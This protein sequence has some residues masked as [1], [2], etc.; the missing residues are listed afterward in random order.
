MPS[1]HYVKWA[2][3]EKATDTSKSSNNGTDPRL[4]RV[5]EIAGVGEAVEVHDMVVRVADKVPANR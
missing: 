3:L 4:D 2:D 5:L 1:S